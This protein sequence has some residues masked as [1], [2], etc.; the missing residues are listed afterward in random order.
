MWSAF[1]K[2]LIR[3]LIW[4]PAVPLSSG[5]LLSVIWIHHTRGC[6]RNLTDFSA[7]MLF[8]FF[9]FHCSS[10][11]TGD[12]YAFLLDSSCLTRSSQGW[13]R[14]L[15]RWPTD[16]PPP[17]WSC[18]WIHRWQH[19]LELI[20][21]GWASTSLKRSP[22]DLEGVPTPGFW[23]YIWT[24]SG[25]LLFS[26]FLTMEM[27]IYFFYISFYT[28]GVLQATVGRKWPFVYADKSH[29]K[30]IFTELFDLLSSWK[31]TCK[32]HTLTH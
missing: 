2:L 24:R 30:P 25:I 26:F 17:S 7:M 27:Q 11:W 5:T 15:V 8:V 6:N 12:R 22:K 14:W 21:S 9:L 19:V 1:I 13:R 29:V 31:C 32:V 18:P 3:T 4:L 16:L 23:E 28:P 10:V 20:T